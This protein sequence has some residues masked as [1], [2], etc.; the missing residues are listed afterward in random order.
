MS[1]HGQYELSRRTLLQTSAVGVGAL[2]ALSACGVKSGSSSSSDVIKVGYVSP[3]TGPLAPFGQADSYVIKALASRLNSGVKIGS[4]SH[5]IQVIVKDSQSTDARA[6]DVASDLI[7]KDKVDL[8]LVSS[9]PDTTN[10][11]SDQCESNGV[12]CISTVAPWQSWFFGR[13][14]KPTT[15]YK[16]TYHFFWGLEDIEAV[17]SDM[18]QQV[19]TNKKIGGLWP[20]DS[21]GDAFA[22]T[23]TGFPAIAKKLHY[24]VTDPGRYPDGTQDF[25]AQIS[26]FKSADCDILTGVPIPPDFITFYKQAAQQGYSPKLVTLAKALLFPSTVEALGSLGDNLGSEVWWTPSHPFTS[27][28]TGQSAKQLAAA[29]EAGTKTQW[30]QPIGFVHALFEVAYA[31]I[32]KAGGG[33]NASALINAIKSLSLNTIVGPVNWGAGPVP[34]VAKTPLVGGQWRKSSGGP[35]PFELVIVSNKEHPNIPAGGKVQVNA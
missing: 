23:T 27:S 34:N 21:D 19:T 9:T 7:L 30:I 35:Y 29:F 3:E 24:S 17:Y 16:W 11:V 32:A 15:V 25:T 6:A 2:G 1:D 8:M 5:K 4:K 33:H 14:A 28:L 26:R 22:A 20:N 13:G 18:W 31:A 10:P 12:P